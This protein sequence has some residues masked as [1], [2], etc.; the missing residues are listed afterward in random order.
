M[1]LLNFL[2]PIIIGTY[3]L[4]IVSLLYMYKIY[5]ETLVELEELKKQSNN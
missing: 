4:S 2:F 3:I 5:A 1:A